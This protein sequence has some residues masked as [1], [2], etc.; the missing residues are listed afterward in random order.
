[1]ERVGHPETQHVSELLNFEQF[2]LGEPDLEDALDEA[3]QVDV[4]ADTVDFVMRI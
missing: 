4:S 2:S 3:L 1:M